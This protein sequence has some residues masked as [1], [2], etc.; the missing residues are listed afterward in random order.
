M[1]KIDL[2][3]TLRAIAT[4]IQ[5]ANLDRLLTGTTVTGGSVAPRAVEPQAATGRARRARIFGIRVSL[6]ELAGKVGVKTGAMLRDV[7]RRANQKIGRAGFKIIPSADVRMRWFAFQAG[8]ER[9]V[10]RPTSGVDEATMES[11][12]AQ[13]AADARAQ[14]VKRANTE[15]QRG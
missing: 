2:R 1:P 13:I 14:F 5:D 6:R 12:S 10:P 11:A 8:T 15:R 7:T 9:Q 4:A 3:K